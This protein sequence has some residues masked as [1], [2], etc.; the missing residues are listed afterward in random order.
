MELQILILQYFHFVASLVESPIENDLRKHLFE[1]YCKAIRPVRDKKTIVNVTFNMKLMQLLDVDER[2][3]KITTQAYYSMH[4]RNEFLQWEPKDWKNID[5]LAVNPEEVWIP[6]IILKN[7]ADGNAVT[8]QKGTDHIWISHT[9]K[10]SWYPKVMLISSFK[11]DVADFPF[12]K[13]KIIFH[14]GSW[15]LGENKLHLFSNDKSMLAKYFVN[16]TEWEL[17][18]TKKEIVSSSYDT[19]TYIEIVFIYLF[20]R[21]PSYCIITAI[22]PCVML[23]LIALFSYLLPP[24]NGERIGVLITSLLAFTVFLVEVNASLPRNSDSIPI[25]KVFYMVTM[26]ECVLCFLATCLA[27]R[28]LDKGNKKKLPFRIP[29]WVKRY[30][31]RI[32]QRQMITNPPNGHSN[33]MCEAEGKNNSLS[34]MD[35]AM[36]ITNNKKNTEMVDVTMKLRRKSKTA[37]F[38]ESLNSNAKEQTINSND[39]KDDDEMTWGMFVGHLDN[40]CLYLFFLL[41]FATSVSILIPAYYRENH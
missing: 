21:K 3:E 28:L 41:F 38:S 30:L 6:D 22:L 1:N 16:S 11:A 35:Q 23:M 17:S 25:I 27:I 13:Q 4:W 14:F 7:N 8:I 34:A 29:I 36:E 10:N 15:S 2:E 39:I 32:K 18:E 33:I 26:G 19:D 12:D 24:H 9:G 5:I 37:V 40:V 20:S 31:F